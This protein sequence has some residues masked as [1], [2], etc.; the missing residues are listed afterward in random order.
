MTKK[1]PLEQHK[2]KMFKLEQERINSVW[3]RIRECLTRQK[4]EELVLETNPMLYIFGDRLRPW[5]PYLSYEDNM[6]FR[7][8]V[9]E[10]TEAPIK[11][12]E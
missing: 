5:K 6:R 4:K 7:Y 8:L 11:Q 2:H 3:F 12:G 9:E 1:K 10:Q